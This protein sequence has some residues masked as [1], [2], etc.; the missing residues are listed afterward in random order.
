MAKPQTLH[1]AVAD[2]IRRLAASSD[3]VWTFGSYVRR[4]GGT[5]ARDEMKADGI[6][7][8]DLIYV[9][10]RCTVVRSEYVAKYG[11][12]RYRAVGRNVDG[13][14]MTFIVTIREQK[15]NIEVVTAWAD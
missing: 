15:N 10:R 9:L 2:L 11:E 14:E 3:T 8:A 12:N 5:H 4:D 1:N 6:E 13:I 7:F